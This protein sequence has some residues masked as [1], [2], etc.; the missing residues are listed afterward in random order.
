MR[1]RTL[2]VGVSSPPSTLKS[3]GSSRNFFGISNCARSRAS[4]GSPGR[5]SHL[6]RRPAPPATRRAIPSAPAT[7]GAGRLGHD[8]QD[9]KRPAVAQ[10]DRAG[11]ELHVF[12]RF[13]IGWGAIFLPPAVTMRSFFR[14][15]IRRKPSDREA[16]CRRCGTSPPGRS[17]P[18]W[19]PAFPS[20]HASRS[21]PGSGPPC[22]RDGL[23]RRPLP[24]SQ[25][26]S[27]IAA[28]A[29]CCGPGISASRRWHSMMCRARSCESSFSGGI[30]Q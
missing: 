10:H 23:P 28:N 19:P 11:D 20:T 6:R 8:Q 17:P 5:A 21:V 15:V 27:A 22:L 16:R 13:S 14:S 24:R 25:H 29:A 12:T 26:I 1:R 2:R 30:E 4:T 18:R 3:R 9:R 7:P